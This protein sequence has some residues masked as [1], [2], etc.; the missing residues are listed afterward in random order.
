MAA[1]GGE[2]EKGGGDF[3]RLRRAERGRVVGAVPLLEGAKDLRGDV[4]ADDARVALE[5]LVLDQPLPDDEW[6]TWKL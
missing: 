5:V 3:G 2:G 6:H 4:K 1:Q